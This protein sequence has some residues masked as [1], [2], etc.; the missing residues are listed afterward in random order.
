MK[1]SNSSGAERIGVRRLHFSDRRRQ[2][3][4]SLADISGRTR[5]PL[6]LLE[7]LEQE[8]FDRF[9]P[10][11]FARAYVRAYAEEAC[12]DVEVMLARVIR[13]LPGDDAPD[14]ANPVIPDSERGRSASAVMRPILQ[15]NQHVM[16]IFAFAAVAF[17]ALGIS[18]TQTGPRVAM[19]IHQ[20]MS[21]RLTDG[22]TAATSPRE[23]QLHPV[24][25]SGTAPT[26]AGE[27]KVRRPAPALSVQR[28]I[29]EHQDRSRVDGSF[30]G[31]ALSPGSSTAMTSRTKVVGCPAGVDDLCR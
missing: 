15:I 4:V 2:N 23:V 18:V 31:S 25:T 27:R 14:G 21:P 24:A 11:M 8:R 13:K 16:T 30:P 12:L 20:L 29:A 6:P 17:V 26:L 19:R 28:R 10:G 7:D 22:E 1:R 9:P 5:I 3:G